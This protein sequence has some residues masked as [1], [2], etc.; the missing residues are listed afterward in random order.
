MTP[1]DPNKEYSPLLKRPPE[2]TSQAIETRDQGYVLVEYTVDEMG[3]VI[4]P[5]VVEASTG[6]SLQDAS[7]EAALK[8]RYA[9]RFFQGKPISTEGVKNRFTFELEP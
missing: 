3:F 6:R 1:D 4:N 9:P 5:K 2:Y 7:V 8:F